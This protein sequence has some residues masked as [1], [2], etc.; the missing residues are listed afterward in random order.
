MRECYL[1]SKTF[2]LLHGRIYPKYII[3]HLVAIC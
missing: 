2:I 3:Y 1:S